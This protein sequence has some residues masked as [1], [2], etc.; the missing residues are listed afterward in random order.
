VSELERVP[1]LPP[2]L[3]ALKG[4]QRDRATEMWSA[5]WLAGDGL[6]EATD[7]FLVERYVSL[8]VRRIRLLAILEHEGMLAVGS[9]GQPTAHPAVRI[10]SDI[11]AKLVGLEDRLGLTPDSRKRLVRTENNAADAYDPLADLIE[12][13]E[14]EEG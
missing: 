4:V 13:L 10:V 12:A 11:E 7:G 9:Q 5:L 2:T 3:D 1:D 14:A 8:Q 6:Y